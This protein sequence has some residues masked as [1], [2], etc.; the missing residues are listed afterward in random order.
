MRILLIGH[1]LVEYGD[2]PRL[3][4]GHDVANLGRAGESTAGLLAR[5]DEEVRAHPAADAVA[6]MSG[7]NDVLVGGE[8]FLHDY[9][10]VARRLRRAYPA[11]HIVLHAVLPLSPDWVAPGT[12][13][14]V[15]ERIAAIAVETGVGFLDLTARFSAPGGEPRTELYEADGVHLSRGGYRVWAA[16][17]AAALGA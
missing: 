6:A 17:L 12:L 1:S 7:T 15:N 14:R 13:A 11:A 2:W 9:R 16:A 5:L 10:R 8:D 3:L 4:P